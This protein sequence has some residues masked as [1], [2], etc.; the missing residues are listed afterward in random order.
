MLAVLP[1]IVVVTVWAL[2]LAQGRAGRDLMAVPGSPLDPRHR[3]TNQLLRDGA[4]LVQSA[5]DVLAALGPLGAVP[6]P[7]P[8]RPAPRRAPAPQA[9]RPP[10]PGPDGAGGDVLGRVQERLGPERGS[11]SV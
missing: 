7:S 11:G 9:P 1:A 6:K 3:G 8:A 10:R 5:D 2:H 4:T